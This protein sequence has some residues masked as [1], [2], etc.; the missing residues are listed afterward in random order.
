MTSPVAEGKAGRVENEI[1]FSGIR[2]KA[3]PEVYFPHEDSFL[4]A[5]AAEKHSFGKV[6]DLG[7]GLGIAGIAAAKNPKTASVTFADISRI[8]IENAKLNC[9][10]NRISKPVHFTQ[11]N[12]F[13]ML[14]NA[15]FNTILFNPPY[16]PTKRAEKLKGIINRA[17]DGGK[18]GRRVIDRFLPEFGGH[19]KSG[20]ILLFLHSS[21]TNDGKTYD[22]LKAR[23]FNIEKLSSQRFF[24]EE[25]S[26]LMVSRRQ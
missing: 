26:V 1:V 21:L 19:L 11:T 8:A 22:F 15:H 7:C 3:F 12:L 2:L 9:K 23:H 24:F 6:L 13:S 14:K 10:L 16:L 18:T 5:E 20:G 4:M 17:F 25:L